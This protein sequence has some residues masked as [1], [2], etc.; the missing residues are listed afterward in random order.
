MAFYLHISFP[1]GRLRLPEKVILYNQTTFLWYLAE[2]A[3]ATGI[4]WRKNGLVVQNSASVRYSI[5][6]VKRNNDN[7]SCKVKK[8][9][10]GTMKEEFVLSIESEL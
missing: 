7:Y 8:S 3:P 10:Q 5:G 1:G 2:G 6:I 4:A 9:E